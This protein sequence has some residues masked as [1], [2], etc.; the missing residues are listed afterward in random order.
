MTLGGALDVCLRSE[1]F[2]EG[3]DGDGY[4]GGGEAD[5]LPDGL[6]AH[7]DVRSD[8]DFSA[9][10]VVSCRVGEL[11]ELE[12]DVAEHG[13]GGCVL[14]LGGAN[15]CSWSEESIVAESIGCYIDF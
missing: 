12:F 6:F 11:L 5:E 8:Y 7:A 4:F 9:A 15:C 2:G 10:Y 1:T 14:I 3:T 13:H